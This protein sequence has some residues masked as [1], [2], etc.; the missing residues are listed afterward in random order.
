MIRETGLVRRAAGEPPARASGWSCPG[1]LPGRQDRWHP[2]RPRPCCPARMPPSACTSRHR[3]A[4]QRDWQLRWSSADRSR[5]LARALRRSHPQPGLG[6][7]RPGSA[8][9]QRE[10]LDAGTAD[11]A[12]S[13]RRDLDRGAGRCAGRCPGRSRRRRCLRSAGPAHYW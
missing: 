3:A 2:G 1:A 9:G 10:R 8:Q 5:G 7:F 6:L 11:P 12:A 13:G 4:L